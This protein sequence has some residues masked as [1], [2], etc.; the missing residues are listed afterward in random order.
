MSLRKGTTLIAGNPVVDQSVIEDSPN[1]VAGGAV[2]DALGRADASSLIDMVASANTASGGNGL[3][4]NMGFVE[5]STYAGCYYRNVTVNNQTVQEWL[6]PPLVVGT[7]YRTTERFLGR[8]V[9]V[10]AIDLGSLPANVG[11]SVTQEINEARA[12]V[13]ITGYLYTSGGSNGS[14]A[15]NLPT[16]DNAIAIYFNTSSSKRNFGVRRNATAYAASSYSAVIIA[17]YVKSS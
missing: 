3:Q 13:S 4:G 6:N 1:A 11:D 2:F 15:Y 10:K 9:Y 8:P 17:K 12:P 7:E 5:D 16:Y 14:A